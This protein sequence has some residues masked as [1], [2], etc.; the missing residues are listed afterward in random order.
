MLKFP[1]IL[2]GIKSFI[3]MNYHS[4]FSLALYD[5][6]LSFSLI[7]YSVINGQFWFWFDDFLDESFGILNLLIPLTKQE[8]LP[9]AEQVIVGR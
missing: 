2:F 8:L 1:S 9:V 7:V 5:L 4:V 3:H 6:K